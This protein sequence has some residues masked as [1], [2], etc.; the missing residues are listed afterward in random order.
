VVSG[1][2]EAGHLT[3]I[4]CDVANPSGCD[5]KSGI[6]SLAGRDRQGLSKSARVV[7]NTLNLNTLN[8]NTL[9]LNTLNPGKTMPSGK[10]QVMFAGFEDLS[11]PPAAN[12][13]AEKSKS[14]A[15]TTMPGP[16]PLLSGEKRSEVMLPG[17]LEGKRVFVVDAHGLIYQVFHA[18]PDMT[19]P[20]GQP[21]GAI[22]GFTRD[23]LDLVEKHQ[24]DLIFCAFD[25][26][27]ASFRNEIF[28]GYKA[29]RDSMPEDLQ[30]Q[31]PHIYRMLDAL[32]IATLTLPGYEADDILATV[33]R[34]VAEAGGECVLVTNDKDCRQLIGPQVRVF[35]IRKEIFLTEAELEEDWGIR[36]DQVVDFQALVGDAV[37]DVPGVPL[38]G[39][40]IARELLQ[41]FDTLDQ[42]LENAHQIS[43]KKR[44]EN[45]VTFREQA[46]MSRD[47]VR[48]DNDSP[49]EIRWEA[50]T[51]GGVSLPTVHALCQEFG[52]RRLGDRISAM[53]TPTIEAKWESEYQT[54]TDLEQLQS[55]GA[56]LQKQS[57]FVVVTETTHSN[58]RWAELVGIS[59]CWQEKLAYYIP[60]RG[61]AGDPQLPWEKVAEILRPAFSDANIEKIGQN[62]KDDIVV[63]KSHGLELA[64][65]YFDTMV[66][67]Y[68]LSPGER[69]HDLNDL[70]RRFL[71]HNTMK[72]QELVGSGKQQRELEQ[73]PVQ[74]VTDYACEDADVPMRL[75]PHL[76][77][78]LQSA[79]LKSLFHELEMP[80]VK[81]LSEMEYRGIRAD[82]EHLKMLS[83]RFSGRLVE[84]EGEIYALAGG[85]RFNIDSP[86]QLATVLFERLG[87][88]V[89]K[90][91]RKTG[92][93]TD[94]DVLQELAQRHE[95]PA[96]LL[97]YRQFA[98]LKG[99][100]VDAL[101]A[102][103]HPSTGRVHT[104]FKQDVAATGRLSSKDPNLQN[105]PIRTAEGR[106]I[107]EAFRAGKP[108]WH[109]LAADYSQI[110]L[111]V[112][113][114]FS[115]DEALLESFRLDE[116]IHARVASEVSGVPLADVDKEMRGRAKAVNFGVI[117]GQTPF[118]LAKA[119]GIGKEEATAFIDA[120]FERYPT[121]QLFMQEI[122]AGCR[123]TGYV[124]TILG[125][126]RQV[127]G[128]RDP[129]RRKDLRFRTLA[130]RIAINTVI[131]GSAADLIKTA[132]LR[133]DKRL[134]DEGLEAKML[135]QIHDELLFELPVEET[136]AVEKLVRE[137]MMA[138][139]DLKV[140][141]KVD[142]ATGENWG[143]C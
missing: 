56:T 16:P 121:I 69:N 114:H 92:P 111:R 7:F 62:I 140:V 110:E 117:Y 91:T 133:V 109:L 122:L 130:E 85:E 115:S 116:D 87:L 80:L 90:Q 18:M 37:D 95:M 118:G 129:S 76:S 125:R 34:Q 45:L 82:P 97:E 5:L 19:G 89:I 55:I 70:S 36:P 14:G 40:K 84:L 11:P 101:Q 32:G 94:A 77:Q 131:Q 64:G 71:Q 137:E 68:L 46:L 17:E 72:F 75:T 12:S 100:Y 73:L 81:V 67:D 60:I 143:Q 126:Q 21:I 20:A 57:R 24:P 49:I 31:M 103:I 86:R 54:V 15:A 139:A 113:A 33:A 4:F 50:A 35:H 127:E 78:K 124:S 22:H 2:D 105:I 1:T 23:V 107:R 66:A 112:L 42:V 74:L 58:P 102:L 106:L 59:V 26:S 136:E 8:L 51:L 6:I 28:S 142:V 3:S 47:L 39:P 13:R 41:R 93:S 135:L 141:L 138:A 123:A 79:G 96:K 65:A 119:L 108:G 44:Q 52:F 120:Y 53:T 61:P 29:S 63:L 30:Q 9:N 128:I 134:R 98:K 104:S 10:R 38:I 27:A 88:P 99:T 48:L 25:H 132:M 83:E 43:G